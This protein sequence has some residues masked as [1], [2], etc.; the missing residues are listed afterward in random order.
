MARRVAWAAGTLA[1]AVALG[2][3]AGAPATEPS[4]GEPAPAVAAPEGIDRYP[5]TPN[6]VIDEDTGE[7]ITAR[8]VPS[9]DAVS[10]E[11]AVDAAQATMSAFARPDLDHDA[12][13][14]GLEPLLTQQ[15]ALDYVYADPANV[16]A[17][18]VTGPGTVIEESSA[19]V[20][21]VEVPT[22]AGTYVLILSR[23]DAA[24]PWLTSR[25]SP[26]EDGQ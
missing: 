7:V 17:T 15:A 10:R 23:Q 22:D 1:V 9:W 2:G 24:A 5:G 20:A 6:G 21:T 18:A 25:I 14:V 13:W 16:P 26:L 19:Y 4:Q 3:C 11:A 8:P 12:W